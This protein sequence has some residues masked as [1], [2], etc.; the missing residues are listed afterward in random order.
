MGVPSQNRQAET[1]NVKVVESGLWGGKRRQAGK[2]RPS[3]SAGRHGEPGQWV[4]CA[5]CVVRL[6]SGQKKVSQVIR[7]CKCVQGRIVWQKGTGA[8]GSRCSKVCLKEGPNGNGVLSAASN[9]TVMPVSFHPPNQRSKP[10]N[11]EG[12]NGKGTYMV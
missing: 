8:G 6:L 2:G 12:I 9:L 10:G 4:T 11:K 1:S 5:A 7:S 3:S